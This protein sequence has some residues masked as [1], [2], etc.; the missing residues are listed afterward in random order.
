MALTAGQRGARLHRGPGDRVPEC[1]VRGGGCRLRL[2]RCDGYRLAG[3]DCR[4]AG[5]TS[6][7][8]S[9]FRAAADTPRLA[10]G[11]AAPVN[12]ACRRQDTTNATLR[13]PSRSAVMLL[14]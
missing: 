1:F 14:L 10:P 5:A 8:G 9:A 7:R 6:A 13:P 2:R 3:P 11:F 4:L 12:H